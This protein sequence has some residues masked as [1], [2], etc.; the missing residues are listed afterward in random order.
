MALHISNTA[1]VKALSRLSPATGRP[2]VGCRRSPWVHLHLPLRQ[3]PVGRDCLCAQSTVVGARRVWLSGR[4]RVDGQRQSSLT[5]ALQKK[6]MA[7]GSSEVGSNVMPGVKAELGIELV[8]CFS[9]NYAYLIHDEEKGVT[10]IVDPSEARPVIKALEKRGLALTHILNTHHHHD[11]TG[12]NLELKRRYGGAQVVGPAADKARIPGIDVALQE[13][14]T[15]HF[16]SHL[17][18]V[19]DTPGHT[20]G[21]VCFYF[22]ASNAVFTGDTLFS[23]GCGRLFE[24]T[25]DQMWSSLSKLISLPAKTRVFCGHEYTE[26]NVRFALSVEP[27]NEELQARAQEVKEMRTRGKPTIPST[28]GLECATNPFLRP[29]SEELRRRLKMGGNANDVDVFAAARRAKDRF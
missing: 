9:D 18:H 17:M 22:P 15:W 8:P 6:S 12:G 3:R 13:G 20:R 27:D 21:H 10:G 16:G 28:I 11:H 23:V 1:F 29:S 25:P 5:C 19:L 24:G 26:A 2:V 7:F 4:P 14:D